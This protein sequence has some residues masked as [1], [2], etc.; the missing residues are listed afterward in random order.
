MESQMQSLY[1]AA[2]DALEK[3]LEYI[4]EIEDRLIYRLQKEFP[5]SLD[6]VKSIVEEHFLNIYK[7]M[8][9]TNT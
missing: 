5:Y 4:K 7:K 3:E 1:D 8:D 2:H 6:L 9:D